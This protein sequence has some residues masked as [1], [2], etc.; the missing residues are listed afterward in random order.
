MNMTEESARRVFLT[1]LLYHPL[2]LCLMVFDAM[3]L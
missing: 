1:S 2:L 3:R